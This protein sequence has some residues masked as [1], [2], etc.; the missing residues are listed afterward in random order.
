ML[1][2]KVIHILAHPDK[3]TYFQDIEEFIKFAKLIRD[4][5]GDGDM[6]IGSFF[7]AKSYIDKFC[8][9][10]RI[11]ANPTL[12]SLLED[13]SVLEPGAWENEEGPKGWNAVANDE[14]IVAYFRDSKDAFSYRL[15][16]IN[17]ILNS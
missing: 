1:N 15:T 13:W 4:E 17:Q 7:E 12:D 5:N 11:E 6:V 2:I 9:N 3:T 8:D 10:L 16:K 14:G